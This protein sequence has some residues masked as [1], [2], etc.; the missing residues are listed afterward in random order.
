LDSGLYIAVFY[1]PRARNV[2]VGKL[3]QFHFKKGVYFYM[4]SAQRNLSARLKRHSSKKKSMRWHIDYLSSKAR[5]LGT[6]TISGPRKREC[7]LAK[8][9]SKTFEVPV[10]GFGAS[11]CHCSGHLFMH[12]RLPGNKS[13]QAYDE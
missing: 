10:L 3:G 8:Q 2:C 9:L 1:L 12:L 4:G 13:N 5:M 6:I 7:K 11:D